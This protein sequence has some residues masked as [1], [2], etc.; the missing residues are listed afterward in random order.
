[1]AARF[2]AK[3]VPFGAVGEDDIGDVRLQTLLYIYYYLSN[4]PFLL[5][6]IHKNLMNLKYVGVIVISK[7]LLLDWSCTSVACINEVACCL[8]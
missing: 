3:I 1:M 5:F 6:S 8:C 7:L 2:G 4:M